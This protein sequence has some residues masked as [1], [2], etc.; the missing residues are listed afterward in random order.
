MCAASAGAKFAI[1]QN[2][3]VTTKQSSAP[4]LKTLL[5]GLGFG[6]SP[7]WHKGRLWFSNW[8]RQEI[9]AVDRKSNSEVMVRLPFASFPFSIAWLPNGSLLIL[10][11]SD[12]PLMRQESNGT[13]VP[14]ADLSELPAQ[15]WNEIVVDGRGNAY[16]NGG[17]MGGANPASGIIALVASDGSVRQ[18]AEGLAFPNGMAVTPDNSTLILAESFGKR[19]TAFDIASSGN[20]S[21][22]RVW[23]DLKDGAPDGITADAEGAV[24][25]ADVPNKRCVRVRQGGEI[26]QTVNVD[27]GCFACMLGGTDRKTLFIMA[28]EWHG[29]EKMME[30]LGTGQVLTIKAPATGVGWP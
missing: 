27:R 17:A 21:N 13:L 16:V 20:L 23:A 15:T 8:G 26:L 2:R 30:G 14:H 6:E 24:W 10:S 25:Y 18:V 28:A 5:T 29:F 19:L 12:R 9:V 7:R 4:G 11:T 22:R 3:K 1:G